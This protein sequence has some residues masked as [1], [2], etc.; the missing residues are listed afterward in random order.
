M[1]PLHPNW[2]DTL[3]TRLAEDDEGRVCKD[4]SADACYETPGNFIHTLIANTLSSL[5]DKL[6]SAKTT[7]PWLLLHLGAPAWMLSLLVPIRESGSMLP[8]MLIGE[9]VRRQPVRKWVWVW[10]GTLQG[11]S[12]M[13]M[14]WTALTLEGATAG[15]VLL[16]LLV[17]FSLARG[18][19]S[20]AYKDVQGKT[21]PKTRRGRLSGWISAVSGLAALGVGILLS[22]IQT[23]TSQRLYVGLLLLAALC[24]LLAAWRFS[25]IVEFPGATDG[26]ANGLAAALK[27]LN[28]LRDDKPFRRFVIARALAMGSGLAAPFYIALARDDLGSAISLLGLFI[29]I[30]GLAG[31]VSSPV[32]GRWADHS[33]RQVFAIA[34]ALAGL[35]S[36]AVAVISWLTLSPTLAMAVYLL[37]FFGLGV[38]HAG[39]RLGRKTY[40]VD[41]ASGNKRTDYVA[42]SNS[43]IGA[44]LLLTGLAGALA[45]LIS[46]QGTLILLGLAGLA[47]ALMS[48][49]WQHVSG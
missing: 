21:I 22:L 27:K 45:A 43:V 25:R 24:W 6:A 20:V 15:I 7:L 26:G 14:G 35:L 4:I 48:L 39:V 30:E 41:M 18:A 1:K 3:Y 38:A 34:S 5:A 44:V 40:M 42:V 16:F 28:L 17:L 12:L 8:Q 10:G 31:L 32:W 47:G 2:K 36:I 19:C 33:S 11:L 23:D 9:L 46:V 37:A 29:A 49:Q 13:A